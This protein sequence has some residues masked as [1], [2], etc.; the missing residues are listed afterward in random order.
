MNQARKNLRK[1][2]DEDRWYKS[3]EHFR[4]EKSYEQH[5]KDLKKKKKNR[6]N[7]G[8]GFKIPN[9]RFI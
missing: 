3:K 6:T 1:S 7:M 5:K 9:I 4:T 2:M 8:I